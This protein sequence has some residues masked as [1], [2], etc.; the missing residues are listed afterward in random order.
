MLNKEMNK[1]MNVITN[2]PMEEKMDKD[3]NKDL[4]I[5][6]MEMN[7]LPNDITLDMA[8]DF[9]TA[10]YNPFYFDGFSMGLVLY[11]KT[12]WYDRL[13]ENISMVEI[14]YQRY[15]GKLEEIQIDLYHSTEDLF[16]EMGM[17][18]QNE[19]V[20]QYNFMVMSNLDYMKNCMIQW[21]VSRYRDNREYEILEEGIRHTNEVARLNKLMEE[22]GKYL[23]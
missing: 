1:A 11:H 19:A 23:K 17:S 16:S 21:L 9:L 20:K 14:V 8:V 15:V 13:E 5:Q 3:R 2:M 18:F 10:T 22:A 4:K 6:M 12:E 7:D